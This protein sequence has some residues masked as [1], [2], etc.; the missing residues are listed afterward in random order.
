MGWD[1]PQSSRCGLEDVVGDETE[2]S[3]YSKTSEVNPQKTSC[4]TA[5]DCI[6]IQK[7]KTKNN[8]H[9]YYKQ[10]VGPRKN[11]GKP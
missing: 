4:R 5:Q 10:E 6:H 7:D 8:K 2:T 3:I 1:E 11:M 9:T